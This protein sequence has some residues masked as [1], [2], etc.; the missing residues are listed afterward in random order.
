MATTLGGG[1]F[2][3]NDLTSKSTGQPSTSQNP[4]PAETS[5][6]ENGVSPKTSRTR[7]T[8]VTETGVETP[9]PTEK[10]TDTATE[11]E[12]AEAEVETTNAGT[13]LVHDHDLL[14]VR[15]EFDVILSPYEPCQEHI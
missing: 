13:V 9:R 6:D 4:T 5:A 12:A 7:A 14:V 11:A 15:P 1:A 3:P 2:G 8:S 10:D